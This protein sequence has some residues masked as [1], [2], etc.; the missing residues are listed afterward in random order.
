MSVICPRSAPHLMRNEEFDT[1][2]DNHIDIIPVRQLG[3]YD[4]DRGCIVVYAYNYNTLR[5]TT[6]A[7]RMP[8]VEDMYFSRLTDSVCEGSI[9]NSYP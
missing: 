6:G 5:I 2:F 3:Y 7:V 4:R 9:K 1:F 8:D